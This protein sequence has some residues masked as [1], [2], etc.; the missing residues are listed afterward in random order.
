MNGPIK[1]FDDAILQT[2]PATF[3]LLKE[4]GILTPA[5][6]LDALKASLS[7]EQ[8]NIVEQIINLNPLD[9][10]VRTPY[11]GE[12]EPVPEDLV[13]VVGQ[14]YTENGEQ[15]SWTTSMPLGTCM[16]HTGE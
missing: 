16:K 8:Q 6:T 3:A 12:L 7:A 13:K 2:F 11:A 10:D 9:Y 4:Q 1:Y 14:Q 5:L 15:R